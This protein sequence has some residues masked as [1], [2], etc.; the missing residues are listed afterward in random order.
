MF[1]IKHKV[2]EKIQVW[3]FGQM[4]IINANCIESDAYF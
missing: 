3:Q 1:I 4:R 2:S